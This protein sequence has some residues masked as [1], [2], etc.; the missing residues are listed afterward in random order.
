MLPCTRRLHMTTA[1]LPLLAWIIF[2]NQPCTSHTWPAGPIICFSFSTS[3]FSVYWF[4]CLCIPTY[5]VHNNYIYIVAMQ[6]YFSQ[7]AQFRVVYSSYSYEFEIDTEGRGNIG[8][9]MRGWQGAEMPAT[10]DA[11]RAASWLKMSA[12]KALESELEVYRSVW[13]DM[14]YQTC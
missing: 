12:R 11:Y 2:A 13:L 7:L 6:L 4:V 8:M 5:H 14:N 1:L 9:M 3:F 10:H